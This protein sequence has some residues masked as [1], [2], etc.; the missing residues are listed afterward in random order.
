MESL[1]SRLRRD[2][3]IVDQAESHGGIRKCVM[4][5][6]S[7][8]T[9][10]LGIF[11]LNDSFHGI[12]DGSGTEPRDVGGLRTDFGVTL[13]PSSSS[14]CELTDRLQIL[15]RMISPEIGILGENRWPTRDSIQQR[16]AIQPS[17]DG[18]ESCGTFRMRGGVVLKKT[19]IHV[20]Q[21]HEAASCA[22]GQSAPSIGRSSTLS[23]STS[24][25]RISFRFHV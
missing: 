1:D 9:Q 2:S 8:Q 3:D 18:F 10:G 5:G 14:R 19:V 12:D 21:C 24:T 16:I 4:A 25:C 15:G 13:N 20:Q 22:S 17:M 7:R 23:R 11:L 6:W